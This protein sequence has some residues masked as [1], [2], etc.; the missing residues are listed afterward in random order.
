MA[1]IRVVADSGCDIPKDMAD[2]LGIRLVPL[3]I[4]FGDEERQDGVDLSPEEFYRRLR[5][6]ELSRTTQPA[7]AAFE[8]VYRALA[9]EGVEAIVSIHLSSKLSGTMQSASL[10]AQSVAV[11]VHV[12]DSRSASLGSGL[13][14]I[15][16]ARMARDGAS[17]DEILERARAIVA[18]QQVLFMVDTLEYL[19]RNGRIGKAQA[20][21][22]GLLNLKPILTL[23]DG[24]VAPLERA[25]GRAKAVARL[26][27][28]LAATAGAAPLRVAVLHGDAP[29]E[30]AALAGQI[31]A[32]VQVA[33][34]FIGLLGPTIGT[35]VGPGTLGMVYYPA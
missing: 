6:G 33:E 10:A 12:V 8:A 4:H 17:V 35:H 21:L 23:E 16:A 19:Q 15:E 29:A 24:I 22:G 13:I 34:L 31:R 30:A 32:R 9:E 5:A 27:D 1:K 18:Q 25:R 2:E 20:F 14:A 7:P 3:T 28:R 26:L 11:P